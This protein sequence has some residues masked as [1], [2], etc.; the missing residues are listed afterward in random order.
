MTCQIVLDRDG[1]KRCLACHVAVDRGEE[2]PACP[3]TAEL[4][5]AP[6]P[7]VYQ[8]R[9]RPTAPTWCPECR[10]GNDA[11]GLAHKPFCTRAR[12]VG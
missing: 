3:A 4:P 12:R 1:G 8:P 9:E 10:T 5:L 2:L 7:P 11:W 6:H